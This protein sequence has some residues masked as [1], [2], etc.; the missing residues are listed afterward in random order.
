MDDTRDA[1]DA[2]DGLDGKRGWRVELSKHNME[3]HGSRGGYGAKPMS[4]RDSRCYACGEFGHFARDCRN[5]SYKG[6]KYDR[7]AT[8]YGKV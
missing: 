8:K 7:Y 5:D 2:V 6:N 3:R 4:I 1:E